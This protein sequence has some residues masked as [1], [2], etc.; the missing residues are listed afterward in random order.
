MSSG[1]PKFGDI[2]VSQDM[3]FQRRAWKVQRVGWAVWIAVVV[4]ALVGLLGGGPLSSATAEA[5]GGAFTVDYNRFTRH[6]SPHELAVRFA[7]G[8][9]R[10]DEVRISF[11]ADYLAGIVLETP[12][13]E[14]ESVETSAER[15]TYVFSLE[16]PRGAASVTFRIMH[17][18][19]WLRRG[20]VDVDGV[21]TASFTQL[22]YP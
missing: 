11:P 10:G 18:G 20:R 5:A 16:R 13:P 1:V 12:Y 22:V 15:I 4:V 21:G 14:P 3:T 17:D 2:E 8:A 19:F 9:V 7:P 6:R